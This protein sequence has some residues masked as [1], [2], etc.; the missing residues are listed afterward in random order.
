MGDGYYFMSFL[1][2]L[3]PSVSYFGRVFANLGARFLISTWHL[4]FLDRCGIKKD[5]RGSSN[6]RL[7]KSSC[8][9]HSSKAARRSDLK[10]TENVS[11]YKKK[12]VL[13]QLE[14]SSRRKKEQHSVLYTIFTA[15]IPT[16]MRIL[17]AG[18]PWLIFV[19]PLL[20]T[21]LELL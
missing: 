3:R 8:C 10:G 14:L 18:L 6:Y 16:I 9:L 20:L 19:S 17:L 1:I 4:F 21:N 13:Q 2:R 12:E 5:L 11:A 7:Q 15:S